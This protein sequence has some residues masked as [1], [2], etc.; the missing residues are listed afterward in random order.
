MKV[1]N[2]SK[3]IGTIIMFFII[4]ASIQP[5]KISVADNWYE[6][7]PGY[8]TLFDENGNELTTMASEMFKDDEY[9]SSDNKHYS[10]SRVNK[11]ERKLTLSI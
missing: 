1:K 5:T 7:E 8:Y 6:D 2:K 10:I 9:I 4:F 11:G 3:L